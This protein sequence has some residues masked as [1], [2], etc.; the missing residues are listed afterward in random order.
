MFKVVSTAAHPTAGME[1]EASDWLTSLQHF[2]LAGKQI[3][4]PWQQNTAANAW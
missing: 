4:S 1:T 2:N 3:Q